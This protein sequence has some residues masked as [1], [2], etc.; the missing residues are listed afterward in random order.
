M[1]LDSIEQ[2]EQTQAE[3]AIRLWLSSIGLWTP[4]AERFG[5]QQEQDM[6]P[7][8]L[9]EE[10]IDEVLRSEG[11]GRIGCYADGK[12]YVVPIAYAYDGRSI[13]A[14]SGEGLKLR[15][16]RANPAVCFEVD[17][18]ESLTNW[19]SVIA[20]GRFEELHGAEAD[21]AMLRLA[22]RLKSLV[23]DTQVQP[24]PSQG[25]AEHQSSVAAEPRPVVYRIVLTERTGRYDKR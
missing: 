1:P 7:A 15:M 19:Q 2:W 12:V 6:L 22:E 17:H 10:Q 4:G 5:I 23:A 24:P 8:A 18:I 21:Q 20:W 25:G 13:Y 16:L 9:D 11:V 14:H 3:I